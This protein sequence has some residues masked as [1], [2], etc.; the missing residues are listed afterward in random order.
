[1]LL[2]FTISMWAQNN[3]PYLGQT[4]PGLTALRFPPDSLLAD[5]KWMWHGSPMFTYDGL[6]MFWTEYSEPSPGAY[7]LEIFTMRVENNNWSPI[8]R[9]SFADTSYKENNPLFITGA[10]TLYYYSARTT[11]FINQVTRT[12]N[13]WG[14]PQALQVPIPSGCT[15]GNTFS[16][17]KNRDIYVD[18]LDQTTN[19]GNI[20]I[21]HFQNGNYQLAQV[22][23]PEINSDCNEFCPFIDPEGRYLIF[24]SDRPGGYGGQA[25]LYISFRNADQTWSDAINMGMEINS[26]GA[27]FPFV[28]LDKQYLFF[29]T[30]KPGDIGYNPYW[31]SADIIDSLYVLTGIDKAGS[32]PEQLK[33]YQ[34]QP[35]PVRDQT[36]FLFYLDYAG[37][38]SFEIYSVATGST[39]ILL[40][41]K[42]MQKGEHSIMFNASGLPSGIYLYKLT[43]AEGGTVTKKMVVLK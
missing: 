27:Y 42:F 28:T 12:T 39:E 20:C 14:Q 32:S 24:G 3:L 8:Q 33:L 15:Y 1:M 9:P 35:N 16:V 29:V 43:S 11:S 7:K 5:N 4:P 36:T 13:T 37:I 30:G 19:E 18:L 41:N 38:I 23:G 40:E 26:T 21:S 31:I 25:D 2:F 34:N 10:D 22:L 17:N 6:E